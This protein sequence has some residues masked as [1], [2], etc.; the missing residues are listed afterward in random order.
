LEIY[1]LHSVEK[2][3]TP[4]LSQYFDVSGERI[5][6]ICIAVRRKILVAIQILRWGTATSFTLG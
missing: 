3:T 2:D 4:E 1:Q 5:W 6:E